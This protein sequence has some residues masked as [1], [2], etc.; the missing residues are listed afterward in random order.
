MLSELMPDIL[1]NIYQYVIEINRDEIKEFVKDF[2]YI[3][4]FSS[5]REKQI[6]IYNYINSLTQSQID[7]IIYNYGFTQAIAILYDFDKVGLGKSNDEICHEIENFEL[8]KKDRHVVQLIFKDAVQ[9]DHDWREN[10]KLQ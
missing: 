6:F 2:K 4:S 7:K 10:D 5:E 3:E 8:L 1:E 9:F